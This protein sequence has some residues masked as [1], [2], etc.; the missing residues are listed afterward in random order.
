[1]NPRGPRRRGLVLDFGG[2]LTTSLLPA[3]LAFERREGLAEGTLLTDL[4]LAP[5]GIRI[6]EDL[7]RGVIGQT[8]WNTVAG[9]LLRLRPDNLLGR[10]FTDLRPEPAVIVAVAVARRAGVKV[11]ILSNS[12]G[13]TPWNLYQG[14]ALNRLFDA[15]VLSHRHGVRKPDPDIY[16]LLLTRLGVTAEECVFVDDT[17]QH[18]APAAAMGF[19]TVHAQE[20]ARTV[21]AIEAALGIP[22]VG[23]TPERTGR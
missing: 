5:E 19:T 10:I 21:A 23:V 12:V 15:V 11:G 22:L 3:A 1:M 16:R 13:L 8:E 6:T 2:V 4:C 14:Y 17:A 18:L 7:E 20:P 9:R